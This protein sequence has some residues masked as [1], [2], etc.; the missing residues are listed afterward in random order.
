MVGTL[1][2]VCARA[3]RDHAVKH[4]K[5]LNYHAAVVA[6]THSIT[7]SAL[8]RIDGGTVSPSAVA[9]LRLMT[10]KYFVGNWTGRPEGFA[11]RRML[12]T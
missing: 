7:S 5:G 10:I 1:P 8:S 4:C 3:A 6:F 12:S 2:A 11:P 9:V